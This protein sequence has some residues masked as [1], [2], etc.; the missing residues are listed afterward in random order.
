MK[1]FTLSLETLSSHARPNDFRITTFTSNRLIKIDFLWIARPKSAKQK[2]TVQIINE[3]TELTFDDVQMM[4]FRTDENF[5]LFPLKQSV[6]ITP[7]VEY[8]I[9]LEYEN[10][11]DVYAF[12]ER[13]PQEQVR[14]DLH[15]NFTEL[16]DTFKG[17]VCYQNN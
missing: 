2:V 9:D 10:S 14:D 1:Y 17:I 4:G 6:E 15:L 5:C 12:S 13:L 3:N 11:A 7:N 16:G 8:S